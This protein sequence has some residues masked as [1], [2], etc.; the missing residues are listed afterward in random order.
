MRAKVQRFV[1]RHGGKGLREDQLLETVDFEKLRAYAKA[2]SVS[3]T[4]VLPSPA[5]HTIFK[6]TVLS[7]KAGRTG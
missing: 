4:T 7:L 6:L 3:P 2:N 1:E 5:T